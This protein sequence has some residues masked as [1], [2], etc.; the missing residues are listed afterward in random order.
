MKM[1]EE[2]PT[3]IPGAIL[4]SV[5]I[6]GVIIPSVVAPYRIKKIFE[7]PKKVLCVW[8]QEPIS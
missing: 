8:P 3:I 5:A 4:L 7:H 1:E 2:E 6:M